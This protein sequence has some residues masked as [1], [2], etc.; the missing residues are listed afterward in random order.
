M[1]KLRN[2]LVIILDAVDESDRHLFLD[3]PEGSGSIVKLLKGKILVSCRLIITT[4]PWRIHEIISACK[5]FTRL[6]LGGFSRADVKTY[7]RQFFNAKEE[8]GESLLKYMEQNGVVA[9]V[10]SV[11][12]MT[13]LICIYWMETHTEEIPNRIGELYDAIFNIMHAHLHSKKEAPNEE[14]AGTS[15][16]LGLLKQRLGKM[17]LEG[18]WPP[19]NRLVFSTDEVSDQEVVAEACNM[20]LLSKQ[21]AR[22]QTRQLFTRK[23]VPNY[24][25][26]TLTFVHKSAQEKCAGAYFAHLVDSNPEELKS[27]LTTVTTMQEALSI[28]L[29]LRFASGQNPHAAR[30]I[31]QRLLDIF[32]SESHSL[33]ADYYEENLELD[34]TLK[35]QPFLEMCLNCN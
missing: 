26:G 25:K 21:E 15:I 18:L 35:I 4:R 16:D 20:G 23:H 1:G 31:L 29:V 27:R 22:V 13:L 28:Q 17:A 7:I 24:G 33:I 12:L 5:S 2:K 30:K 10:S 3:H 34:D 9:D 14:N 19:E 32:R 6:D 11:P 8:L